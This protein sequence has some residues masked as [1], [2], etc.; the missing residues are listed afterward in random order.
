MAPWL[1]EVKKLLGIPE[2]DTSKD[3]VIEFLGNIALEMIQVR[4]GRMFV[5]GTYEET[6]YGTHSTVYL[7]EK[8]VLAVLS[9]TL[10]GGAIDASGYTVDKPRGILRFP[11]HCCA[12]WARGC[13]CP[14]PMLVLYDANGALPPSWVLLVVADALRVAMAQT[15]AS[16]AFGFMAHKVTVTDVGAVDFGS[17]AFG[18]SPGQ[19]MSGVIDDALT[20]WLDPVAAASHGCCD[21]PQSSRL[22]E[23]AP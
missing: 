15:E 14:A 6:L 1:E 11:A 22:V 17:S 9:V 13:G 21:G 10:G 8:P 18:S 5:P 19:S 4:T 12:E 16:N 20:P 3:A 7:T 23:A 2:D